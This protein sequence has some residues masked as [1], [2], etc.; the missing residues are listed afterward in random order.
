MTGIIKVSDFSHKR[1]KQSD[2]NI[3]WDMFHNIYHM[4]SDINNKEE[5]NAALLLTIIS[6][7]KDISK[8]IKTAVNS[9]D[10]HQNEFNFQLITIV[11]PNLRQI[12][13][14]STQVWN[15]DEIGFD[16]NGKWHKVVCTDKLFQGERMWEVKTG[17]RAPLYS[18]DLMKNA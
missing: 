10:N 17:E 13:L 5:K 12:Q 9:Y 8:V 6:D 1:V 7:H 11:P 16:P 14:K 4:Y 3:N 2:P 18:Q 15:C